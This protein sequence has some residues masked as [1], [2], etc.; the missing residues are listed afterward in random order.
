MTHVTDVHN[1]KILSN[2]NED[3]ESVSPAAD[4]TG[5]LDRFLGSSLGLVSSARPRP[6][7]AFRVFQLQRITK[8]LHNGSESESEWARDLATYVYATHNS[9][10]S[11][12]TSG[13]L[14]P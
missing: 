3:Y 13:I 9:Q 1:D 8:I 5:T 10:F 2:D 14:L 6:N 11:H 4:V 12:K 7:P